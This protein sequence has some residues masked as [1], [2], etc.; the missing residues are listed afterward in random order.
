M[1]YSKKKDPIIIS[2]GGGECQQ[3]F[4][5]ISSKNIYFSSYLFRIHAAIVS[6]LE[7][8]LV[9]PK[10]NYGH[11]TATHHNVAFH[12]ISD[13]RLA[14]LALSG[15]VRFSE[16]APVQETPR[17][18]VGSTKPRNSKDAGVFLVTGMA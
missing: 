3:D 10:K 1:K 16:V 15:L 2:L 14:S 7:L 4:G 11:Y 8:P 6:S 9:C 12:L 13:R 5:R 18:S 17:K